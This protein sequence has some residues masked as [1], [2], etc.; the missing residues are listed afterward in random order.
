[1]SWGRTSQGS[2]KC[3]LLAP[4]LALLTRSV[5]ALL[6]LEASFTSHLL[7]KIRGF[8]AP[9]ILNMQNWPQVLLLITP[10]GCFS[11]LAAGVLSSPAPLPWPTCQSQ[12][13][14]AWSQLLSSSWLGL[15]SVP[16]VQIPLCPGIPRK[17]GSISGLRKL[18]L[19]SRSGE[20]C[21]SVKQESAHF[22]PA[23]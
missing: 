23:T 21:D 2:T 20:G 22:T 12:P 13:C 8:C 11:T 1:M 7:W 16:A 10:C 4:G 6:V 15:I 14:G 3:L 18:V 19:P 5:P 17:Q 9:E